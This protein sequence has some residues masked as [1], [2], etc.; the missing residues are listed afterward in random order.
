[1][2]RLLALLLALAVAAAA[3]APAGATIVLQKGMAGVRLGMTKAQ[4]R[5]VLGAPLRIAHA[6]NDFGPYTQFRY[7]HRVVV[8]FQ[9]NASATAV[10]TTGTFERTVSGLGVG[11]TKGRVRATLRGERCQSFPGGSLCSLGRGN[12]G[13][14]GTVFFFRA[15][16][17][18]RVLVA[19]VID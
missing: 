12:P 7:P 17:V 13:D 16:K 1:M 9:G 19:F 4:V 14:R 3:A 18:I 5:G 15:G 8:T 10:Q 6:T 2:R 11:S